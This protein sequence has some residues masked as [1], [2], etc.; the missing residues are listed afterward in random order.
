MRVSDVRYIA[1]Q[2]GVINGGANPDADHKALPAGLRGSLVLR[3]MGMYGHSFGG[4]TAATVVATDSRFAA[5][6]DLDGFVIGPVG[7]AGTSKPFLMVGASDHDSKLDPTWGTFIP[8]LSGWHRWFGVQNAG[9]Y[10]F[11]DLGG[12][13][14]KWGLAKKIKPKDPTTWSQ[15]FGDMDDARSQQIDRALVT[16]FFQS[17]LDGVAAPVLD[18]P[19]KFFPDIVNRTGQHP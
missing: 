8:K 18:T 12:S 16:G 17:R 10:R 4:G 15:V 11:I 14:G 19:A 1:D 7:R 9:H 2:L 5:G 6:I 13:I 3:G